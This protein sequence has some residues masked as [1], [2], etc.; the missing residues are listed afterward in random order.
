MRVWEKEDD[1]KHDKRLVT[2]WLSHRNNGDPNSLAR[3][4][5]NATVVS[6]IFLRVF[7]HGRVRAR[8]SRGT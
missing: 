2:V 4:W 7:V 5:V 3:S 8:R 1:C 6:D